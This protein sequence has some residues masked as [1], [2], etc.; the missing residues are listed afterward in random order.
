MDLIKI[1]KNTGNTPVKI[2]GDTKKAFAKYLKAIQFLDKETHEKTTE[3]LLYS[4]WLAE[5]IESDDFKNTISDYE[6]LKNA[7]K[8]EKA[9]AAAERKAAAAAKAE[10]KK[11]K[12]LANLKQ[13]QWDLEHPEEAKARKK[14]MKEAK[15][16]E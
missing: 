15:E 12:R 14:A 7:E 10:E 9:A 3:S 4:S 13:Q 16:A 8:E 2:T 5:F 6:A 1:G 11:Q